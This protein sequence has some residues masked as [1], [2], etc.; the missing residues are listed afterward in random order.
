[1]RVESSRA[2]RLA[3]VG[4]AVAMLVAATVS[5]ST[6]LRAW[7]QEFCE[8]EYEVVNDWGS[9]FQAQVSITV[10]EAVDGWEVTWQFP[11]GTSVES[12]WNVDWS[13][14]GAAFTGS[15]V[16]WNASLEAG[17]AREVFGFIGAGSAETPEAIAV[18]GQVCDGQGGGGTPT[19]PGESE[20]PTDPGDG[21][22]GEAVSVMPLGDSITGSPGCWRGLLWQQ[23]TD[24]GHDVD[25]VGSQSQACAPAGSDPDHEGHGGFL[26]TQSV[27]DGST[28]AWL[29]QN[30]PEVL[31]M[32]F[33]TNDVWSAIPPAQILEAFTEIVE[34]LRE[35]NP[36]A[37]ILV[38]QIIPLH[39]DASFG[40]TDCPQRVIDLNAQIPG[41]AADLTTER[42]PITV[43]DQWTGW[44][45]ETD[46]YDGVHPDEDG[47]V[48][49]AATW[50]EALDPIL[51]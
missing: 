51:S 11:S 45:P 17:Q 14:S 42:S 15:D 37:V 29:E 2:M 19:D 4:A 23:L 7:A 50:F 44:D 41:W 22:P 27:A 26:V 43:V 9:G 48:K 10:G 33:G 32:H 21:G 8:L 34:D 38:A 40:C 39:P 12:A 47:N 20:T 13:Q 6:A 30:T 16:G 25:F 46:T 24:A 5:V 31:L 3:A 35:L 18:N 1:M 36:D 28:R 49:M